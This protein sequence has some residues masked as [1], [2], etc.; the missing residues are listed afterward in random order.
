M[1]KIEFSREEEA[2]IVRLIR[3]YFHEELEHDLGDMGAK[4]L[5]D[6]VSEQLGTHYYNRGLY[7]AQAILTSRLDDITDAIYALEK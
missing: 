7:D 1:K 6:F 5:L 3:D 2:A 4:L